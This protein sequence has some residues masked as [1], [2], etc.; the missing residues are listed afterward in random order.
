VIPRVPI[1]DLIVSGGGA[2]NPLLVAQLQAGLALRLRS[3]QAGIK[4]VPS[5]QFGVPEDAK[6]AFA[7]AILAYETFHRRP[8]N[9]PGATG[10]RRP[11]ILGKLVLPSP[12]KR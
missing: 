6:E 8:A 12:E 11:A 2:H 4:I 5:G 9:V 10:A 7:F 1:H 3:G